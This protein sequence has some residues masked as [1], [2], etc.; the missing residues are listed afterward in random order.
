MQPQDCILFYGNM[1]KSKKGKIQSFAQK[2]TV[3]LIYT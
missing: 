3:A 1:S 2:L